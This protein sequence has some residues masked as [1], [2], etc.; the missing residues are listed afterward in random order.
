MNNK[1]HSI[2]LDGVGSSGG[3]KFEDMNISGVY[4]LKGDIIC[5]KFYVSGVL[6]DSK[7]IQC[8]E[9]R[10]SGVLKSSESLQAN[11]I[12][13]SGVATIGKNIKSQKISGE[14]CIKVKEDIESEKV[15]LQGNIIC[16]GLINCEDFYLFTEGESKI[17]EI[18]ATNIEICAKEKSINLLKIFIPKRIKNNHAYIKVIEGDNIKLSNCDVGIV[19]G[20]NIVIGENCK[21]DK[22]EYSESIDINEL[23]KVDNI[24]KI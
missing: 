21:I 12:N 1:L 9:F 22:V 17:G 19:R 3:G 18:G 10:V 2:S 13:V 6:K 7:N 14:G 4:S 5:N 20:K 23:S 15:D 24:N 11:D 8:E 16:H